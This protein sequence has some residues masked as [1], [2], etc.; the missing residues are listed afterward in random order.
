MQ[1]PSFQTSTSFLSC[2]LGLIWSHFSD[3][4]CV[5][6]VTMAHGEDRLLRPLEGNDR[7]YTWM[8]TQLPLWLPTFILFYS[9][10]HKVARNKATSNQKKSV[11]EVFFN[12][13]TF[14]ILCNQICA[15]RILMREVC[16]YFCLLGETI[17]SLGGLAQP[18]NLWKKF[19]YKL[20]FDLKC[21]QFEVVRKTNIDKK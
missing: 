10:L 17:W 5:I 21:S 16:Q 7:S 9:P 11:S 14:W 15:I 18:W 20:I 8:E 19:H 13:D 3:Q 2:Q 12:Q 4:M 6:N 1:N